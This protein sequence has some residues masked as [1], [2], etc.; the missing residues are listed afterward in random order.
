MTDPLFTPL[1]LP[2]GAVLPNRLAK[3]AMEENL[4][5]RGQVPGNRLVALYRRWAMGGVGLQITGN[6]MV[7]PSAMTGPGNVILE[8]G[9]DLDP[10][11]RWA[12]AAKSG[13]GQIWMQISHPGRQVYADMGEQAVSASDV[14]VEIP[15][16][17]RLFG[18]PRALTEPEIGVLVTRFAT[19][20]RLAAEAGFDGVQV[21][22]AH[23][24]LI[25]Q[26]LSPLTNRREDDWGGPLE[27]RARF[28]LEVLKAVRA[29]VPA[30]FCVAVKLNSADFQK[31]GFD[32]EDAERV[33]RMLDGLDLDM[34][35]LSGGSYE[36]PAMQGRMGEGSSARRE[37][38]FVD[39]A[40]RIARVAA[41][42]IMV[43]G[44]ITR[45]P[46][47]RA[48]I[49]ADEAGF[50]V[51][52]LG[53]ARALAFAPDLPSHWRAGDQPEV[54]VPVVSWSNTA[55]ASLGTMAVAKAQL[56]RMAR[57]HDPWPGVPA[58]WAV[59]ADRVRTM[60]RTRRYK[61]W[62]RG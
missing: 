8:E 18:Q 11:R 46:V 41:M 28:L 30:D 32:A 54:T 23:G 1:A 19:T 43:T 61:V 45:L 9:A 40:R 16:F 53:L 39:F 36:S 4:A 60:A 57:G 13:G 47:A 27:N 17:S 2:N 14:A 44:G 62:R 37:A 20:A 5:D 38:Y 3:A 51:S 25:S 56:E 15:G 6:V 58:I 48:A 7:D 24:Y 55:L 59:I 31:G 34:V 12:E 29:V 33:V 22:G 49:E 10:F 52:V 42:P 50:G 26:F 21:H 35:E